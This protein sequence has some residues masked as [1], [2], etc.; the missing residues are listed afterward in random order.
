MADPRR[1]QDI[2]PDFFNDG[3]WYVLTSRSLGGS[4]LDASV[5]AEA[6]QSQELEP[7]QTLMRDGVCLPLQFPGDC[8]MDAQTRFVV[9]PLS[10]E[11]E[12]EWIGRVQGVLNIPDG[13][14]VLMGGGLDEHFEEMMTT[15]EQDPDEISF[16]CLDVPPGRYRV[17]VY[18]FVGSMTV[19]FAWEDDD[20]AR[21]TRSLQD[22]WRSTRP[23]EDEPRWLKGWA[24]EGYAD[25]EEEDL[26]CYIVRLDPFDG[27]VP[28][29]AQD[30]ESRWVS[31]FEIRRAALCPRGIPFG[32]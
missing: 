9:G 8:A 30:E 7:I 11:E 18:A 31:E 23:G 13:E 21:A 24:E 6:L 5:I 15:E 27:S 25:S 1:E 10:E 3:Y 2:H 12:A 4:G 29:P 17:E 19:N 20:E 22:Y 28:L 26:L 14:F 16:H 32:P